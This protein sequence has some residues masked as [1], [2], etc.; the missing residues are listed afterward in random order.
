M[1]IAFKWLR[2]VLRKAAQPEDPSPPFQIQGSFS[3]SPT[4]KPERVIFRKK[5]RTL[6]RHGDQFTL[7]GSRVLHAVLRK[8]RGLALEVYNTVLFLHWEFQ[9]HKILVV[10]SFFF[11]SFLLETV[12]AQF[13]FFDCEMYWGLFLGDRTIDHH[14]PAFYCLSLVQC[15]SGIRH[16]LGEEKVH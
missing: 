16:S 13:E 11:L 14:D 3:P 4:S 9:H 8:D 5:G 6:T 1:N 2:T 10:W 15:H 12:C 7:D